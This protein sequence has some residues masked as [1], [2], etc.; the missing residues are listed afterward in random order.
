MQI[1]TGGKKM[2]F[3]VHT[4]YLENYGAHCEDG[5]FSS[6]NAYWKFKSGETYIVEGLDRIQDAVA[7]VMASQSQNELH[8]KEFPCHYTTMEEWEEE[9]SKDSDDYAQYQRESAWI[10]NPRTGTKR[11]PFRTKEAA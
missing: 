5:K 9:L 4:Q 7:F 10:I 11:V 3:V 8:A 1:N 6:G 2:Q